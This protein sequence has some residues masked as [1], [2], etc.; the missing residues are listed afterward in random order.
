MLVLCCVLFHILA[1]WVL[2][3]WAQQIKRPEF[4]DILMDHYNNCI[5]TF[6]VSSVV[7]DLRWV[8][9]WEFEARF[10]GLVL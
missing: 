2:V 5:Q 10:W 4:L 9:K 1:H 7:V 6:L 3:V 8:V